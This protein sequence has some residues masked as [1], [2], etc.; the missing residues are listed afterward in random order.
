MISSLEWFEP[1][2]VPVVWTAFA[3]L[4]FIGY[5][6]LMTYI[7]YEVRMAILDY[8]NRLKARQF[9]PTKTPY[10]EWCESLHKELN[11]E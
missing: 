7:R 8:A 1:Y 3:V 9:G 11:R 4:T 2:T 5:F 6:I 10:D